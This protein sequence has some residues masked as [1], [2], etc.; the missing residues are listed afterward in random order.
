[1]ANNKTL[2]MATD[3]A[4][5]PIH[6]EARQANVVPGS[7]YQHMFP[8]LRVPHVTEEALIYLGCSGSVLDDTSSFDHDSK[9][10]DNHC[11]PAGFTILAQFIAHDITA[12]KSTP[13][14]HATVRSLFNYRLPKLDLEP[15]YAVSP[16]TTHY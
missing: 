15:V 13:Q 3:N 8:K 14:Q 7:K 6:K 5:C 9:L 4:G 11:I 1:M 2:S 12:D 10:R 16:I